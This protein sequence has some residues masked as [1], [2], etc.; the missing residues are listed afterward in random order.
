ML[1]IYL[2]VLLNLPI[3]I[4]ALPTKNKKLLDL[5]QNLLVLEQSF[6]IEG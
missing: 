5:A 3:F 4:G 1:P 6:E 2:L